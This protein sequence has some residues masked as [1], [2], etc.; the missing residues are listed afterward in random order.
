MGRNRL[1]LRSQETA[2]ESRNAA[3]LKRNIL[4]N[5]DK[6]FPEGKYDVINAKGDVI[7]VF[8]YEIVA[9][10]TYSGFRKKRKSRGIGPK[11]RVRATA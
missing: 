4:N 2:A 1:R 3:Q 8:K 6:R 5:K 11:F 7:R 10:G 9:N